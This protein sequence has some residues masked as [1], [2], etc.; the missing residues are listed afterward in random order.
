MEFSETR[1]AVLA[2]YLGR[3]ASVALSSFLNYCL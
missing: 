2:E 3:R 1:K